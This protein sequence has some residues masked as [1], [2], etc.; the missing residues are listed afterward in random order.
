MCL[1]HVGHS[2]NG[3]IMIV[4]GAHSLKLLKKIEK[5]Q[6]MV[7]SRTVASR[8]SKSSFTAKK[9]FCIYLFF[10]TCLFLQKE[11]REDYNLLS[12]SHE[13]MSLNV[14][15]VSL[16]TLCLVHI[17]CEGP[18]QLLWLQNQKAA[19]RPTWLMRHNEALPAQI[20]PP[21][22]LPHDL[23]FFHPSYPFGLRHFSRG[24]HWLTRKEISSF[25]RFDQKLF[26]QM[27]QFLFRR[28]PGCL[29]SSS[30][31]LC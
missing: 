8:P 22:N 31:T 9:L 26:D 25:K 13:F 18:A 10:L 21:Q 24:L 19:S 11:N 6:E 28:S 23:N 15:S 5:V 14:L 1:I 29:V 20:Y 4:L 7:L 16:L 27:N 3:G 2:I 30:F 17:T 12:W